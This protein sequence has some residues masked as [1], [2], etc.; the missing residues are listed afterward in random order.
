MYAAA[1]AANIGSKPEKD[2]PLDG[3]HYVDPAATDEDRQWALWT[4]LGPLLAAVVSSGTLA[5]LGIIWGLYV[6][7]VPGKQNSFIADHGREMFN[8]ALSYTLYWT[9]GSIA[10]AVVTFGAGLVVFM[11][12]LVVLGLI[13]TIQASIAGAK[14]RYYRYPMCFRFMKAPHEKAAQAA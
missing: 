5:P 13:G 10:V 11:P 3:K 6:M 2:A 7:K 9:V 14:G 8:F 12:F 1:F 4:H